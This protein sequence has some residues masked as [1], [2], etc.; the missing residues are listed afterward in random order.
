MPR[1]D[2]FGTVAFVGLAKRPGTLPSFQAASPNG[3]RT[4]SISPRI[5]GALFETWPFLMVRIASTARIVA[6]AERRARKDC[7]I[8]G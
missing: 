4:K 2:P 6:F 1:Y 8:V 5:P 7:R 3:F